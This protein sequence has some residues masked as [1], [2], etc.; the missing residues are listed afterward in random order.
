MVLLGLVLGLVLLN[1]VMILLLLLLLLVLLLLL[2]MM[3]MLKLLQMLLVLVMCLRLCLRV[4][5]SLLKQA[6]ACFVVV[7]FI[8]S[9]SYVTLQVTVKSQLR[10]KIRIHTKYLEESSTGHFL[11]QHTNLNDFLLITVHEILGLG[12][13]EAVDDACQLRHVDHFLLVGDDLPGFLR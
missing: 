13:A 2:L 6:M 11:D 5:M 8:Q 4:C 9:S 1:L 7:A 3:L 12:D 10:S